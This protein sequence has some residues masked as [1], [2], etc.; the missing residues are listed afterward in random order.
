[1]ARN[2]IIPVRL[3]QE[4]VDRFD[5]LVDVLAARSGGMKLPRSEV[6]R[7]S[8]E[9]GLPVLEAEVNAPLDT[10]S[11]TTAPTKRAKGRR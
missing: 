8:M 3:T 5:R 11:T 10:P 4:D 1:M 9:R 2:I 6:M 7:A